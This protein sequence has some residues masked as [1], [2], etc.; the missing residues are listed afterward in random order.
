MPAA[1]RLVPSA[2][3]AAWLAFLGL[4]A[5]CATAP[6][7]APELRVVSY[8]IRHGAGM[9]GRV[10]LAR[11]AAVL[12]ALSPDLVALQEVDERVKRS[13]GVDQ[14]QQL[15]EAL[16][17]A[18]HFTSFMDYQ[19]GRY[20]LAILSR[21]PIRSHR[22]IPLPP[23]DEPRAALLVE[24]ELANGERVALVCVHLNW[25]ADDAV[26]F[27][28]ARTLCTSL[29]ALPMPYLVVGDFN[30][31]PGSRT[32]GLF[33]ERT[34]AASKPAD[35]R[36]TYPADVPT[37]EIDFV[38]AGPPARW[39]VHGVQVVDERIASDHRPLLAVLALQPAR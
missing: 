9:D 35:A 26:R 6:A 8:N 23:G 27:D 18:A 2:L 21:L 32:L 33:A 29:D 19:G 16:G 24:V 11:T 34:R 15:G 1:R 14:A 13:G 28:Q 30:D 10:D 31:E 4:F 3:G 39:R 17:M 12:R 37:K 22:T 36:F 25:V 38:Q 7:P 20:G 5:A